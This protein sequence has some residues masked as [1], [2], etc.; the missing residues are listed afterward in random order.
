MSILV[1]GM[2]R[3]EGGRRGGN[4]DEISEGSWR[5]FQRIAVDLFCTR[6]QKIFPLISYNNLRDF[7]GYQRILCEIPEGGIN[8]GHLRR[9]Q[10]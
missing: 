8:K 5:I 9:H 7:R 1:P 2:P 3:G 6:N 10:R 4:F